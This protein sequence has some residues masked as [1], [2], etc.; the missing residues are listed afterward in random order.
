M[1]AISSHSV[2][3][4]MY[5]TLCSLHAVTRPRHTNEYQTDVDMY[6]ELDGEHGVNLLDEA[7]LDIQFPPRV[8]LLVCVCVYACLHIGRDKM[9]NMISSQEV[10]G[11]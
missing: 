2:D 7:A 6:T 8:V 5:H 10:S 1:H 4:H 3:K 9:C 11:R